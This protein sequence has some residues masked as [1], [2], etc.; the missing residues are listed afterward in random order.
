[1]GEV[2][3]HIVAGALALTICGGSMAQAGN[4]TAPI[5]DKEIIVVDTKAGSSSSAVAF[6]LL[7]GILMFATVASR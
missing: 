1:M 3:K 4:M 5:L 6:V 7:T 2:M